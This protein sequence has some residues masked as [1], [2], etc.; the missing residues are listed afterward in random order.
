[1]LNFAK[2]IA[3][4]AGSLLVQ[5]LGSA[6]VSNKGDIDL[7]TEADIAA[8][9]LIIDQIRSYYPRHSVL[10]EESGEAISIGGDGSSWKW[11]IDPLDGTTNYAHGYPCFCV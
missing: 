7:V 2:Q 5:R 11:V 10:A 1:M 6:R 3:L 8:E 4:D 9:K